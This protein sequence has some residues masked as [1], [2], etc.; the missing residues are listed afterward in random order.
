MIAHP[1]DDPILAHFRAA[2]GDLYGDRLERVL[3]FGSQ[4]RGDAREDSDYDVAVF[5]RDMPDR[6]QEFDRLADIS[7]HILDQTGGLIH[8]IPYCANALQDRTSLM[9]EIRHEGLDL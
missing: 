8:A 3:L 6:W 9:R 5:L 2:L 7:T 4:A 1:I